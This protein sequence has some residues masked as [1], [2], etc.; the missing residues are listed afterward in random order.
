MSNRPSDHDMDDIV[1][2]LKEGAPGETDAMGLGRIRSSIARPRSRRW[3]A[4]AVAIAAVAAAVGVT[5]AVWP[6]TPDKL[7]PVNAFAYDRAAE[8]VAPADGIL[9]FKLSAET[10]PVGPTSLA[11]DEGVTITAEYPP[12]T[13]DV[14][15]AW[16]DF[17]N[18]LT[19]REST[20][21][22]PAM[23]T[24]WIDDPDRTLMVD[25]LPDADQLLI[26]ERLKSEGENETSPTELDW[27]GWAWTQ[28]FARASEE[29]SCDV[30]ECVTQEG[31]DA[32][33]VT[34]TENV[35]GEFGTATTFSA[36]FRRTDYRPLGLDVHTEYAFNR[37]PDPNVTD[38]HVEVE[39]WET[40][41]R[42]D[43]PDDL[44]E[45]R[46]GFDVRGATYSVMMVPDDPRIDEVGFPV[47][48]AGDG[49]DL[50][51]ASAARFGRGDLVGYHGNISPFQL[52]KSGMLTVYYGDFDW[53]VPTPGLVSVTSYAS[54]DPA[55]VEEF[56]ASRMPR[57]EQVSGEVEGRSYR[58]RSSSDEA[59][60]MA[61]V[62][63]SAVLI[64]GPD[65]ETVLAVLG[66][67]DLAE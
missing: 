58:M 33:R 59:V 2:R 53:W 27:L 28:S 26:S 12:D 63:G 42:D 38:T 55:D 13:T 9:H 6:R 18:Q 31:T 14:T 56:W 35:P 3:I 19:R 29:R 32:W 20:L 44:F 11:I 64:S 10:T 30:T 7:Q 40:L 8:V 24:V 54:S 65:E 60:L 23:S 47:W 49:L 45:T 15:E 48:R 22:Y 34:W 36:L 62:D 50:P 52:H 1:S 25:D 16:F 17:A 39:V 57:E 4:R 21:G 67:L 66:S 61:S 37:Y 5:F 46:T 51:P 43:V 41:D